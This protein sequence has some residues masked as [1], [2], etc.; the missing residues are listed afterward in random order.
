MSAGWIDLPETEWCPDCQRERV[1]CVH[2][3]ADALEEAPRR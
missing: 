1:S 2:L 3:Q